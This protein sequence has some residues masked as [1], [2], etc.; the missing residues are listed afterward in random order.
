MP[1]LERL[2]RLAGALEAAA[3][4]LQQVHLLR[5]S[6]ALHQNDHTTAVEAL[7]RYFDYRPASRTH[8][9]LLLMSLSWRHCM[10]PQIPGNSAPTKDLLFT[11]I[12]IIAGF[13]SLLECREAGCLLQQPHA[14]QLP[15]WYLQGNLFQVRRR[16]KLSASHSF[17]E[18]FSTW[19]R[20]TPALATPR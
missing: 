9:S 20:P 2:D 6:V 7:H 5:H 8:A 3:P 1:S 12:V 14:V 4:D 19:E 18:H 15:S 16:T 13:M 17:L 11:Q 10:P